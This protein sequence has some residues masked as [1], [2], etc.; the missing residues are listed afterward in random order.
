VAVYLEYNNYK[1]I[2]KTNI[3]EAISI[4]SRVNVTNIVYAKWQS[5][6]TLF[7]AE[8]VSIKETTSGKRFYIIPDNN[9]FIKGSFCKFR[10]GGHFYESAYKIELHS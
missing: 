1:Q 4:G 6:Y 10:T 5:R 7:N 2:A 9:S 8:V 3:M